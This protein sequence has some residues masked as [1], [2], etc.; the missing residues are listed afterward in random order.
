MVRAT[1][2][3]ASRAKRSMLTYYQGHYE[4]RWSSLRAIAAGHK[5]GSTYEDFVASVY[6]PAPLANVYN[7]NSSAS[8]SA[9]NSRP[10]STIAPSSMGK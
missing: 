9:S 4:E 6:S 1:A 5:L 3:N 2:I 8:S 7:S 10:A